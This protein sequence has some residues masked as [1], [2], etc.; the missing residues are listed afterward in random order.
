MRQLFLLLAFNVTACVAPQA[1]ADTLETDAVSACVTA[2]A[3]D[4]VALNACRRIVSHPCMD[5]GGGAST[6]GMVMC[7]SEEGEAWT[8]V[9]DATQTRLTASRPAAAAALSRAQEQWRA[10]RD[11]ECSYSVARFGQGS[12]AQVEYAACM[13]SMSADRAIA[14]ILIEKIGD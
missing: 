2:A 9:M 5:S 8:S 7:L 13:A 10:Y 4:E 11:A 12:G 1:Y 3:D 14:L 6:M